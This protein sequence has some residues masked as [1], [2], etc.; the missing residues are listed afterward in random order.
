MSNQINLL[1]LLSDLKNLY[2]LGFFYLCESFASKTATLS[3]YDAVRLLSTIV[4][5]FL[6]ARFWKIKIEMI[7]TPMCE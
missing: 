4:K 7:L 2:L 3:I 5:M 6:F 1:L